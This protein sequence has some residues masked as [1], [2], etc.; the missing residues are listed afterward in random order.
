MT[1]IIAPP[2]PPPPLHHLPAWDYERM[3]QVL[4][5]DR[6]TWEKLNYQID[7]PDNVPTPIRWLQSEKEDP[8]LA[9]SRWRHT[10]WFR[11]E[12]GIDRILDVPYPLYDVMSQHVP[13]SYL[14]TCHSED[15]QLQHPISLE[16]FP[17]INQSALAKLGLSYSEILY[18]YI[19]Y[20][21]YGRKRISDNNVFNLLDLEGGSITM[22][23]G[24]KKILSSVL[25]RYFEK[26]MPE[27]TYSITIVNAP[28]WFNW[29]VYPLIKLI[30]KKETLEKLHVFSVPNK[31]FL[32]HL[33]ENMNVDKVLPKRLHYNYNNN[34]TK[35]SDEGGEGGEGGEGVYAKKQR[36][37]VMKLL[38]KKKDGEVVKDGEVKDG[39]VKDSEVVKK[40]GEVKESEVVKVGEVKEDA[41]KWVERTDEIDMWTVE[42]L[43]K[44]LLLLGNDV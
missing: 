20:T 9:R 21:E 34:N 23:A 28:S 19:W 14:G 36:V 29:I 22:V 12:F 37:L 4:T 44:R 1:S 7:V 35:C 32:L 30:A 27:S 42:G 26:H 16:C 6:A 41:I 39:E 24:Q 33:N 10:M 8:L 43:E 11:K 15:S 40:D 5:Y 3:Q 25:G 13:L 2:P 17:K 18:H 31:S 38:Q